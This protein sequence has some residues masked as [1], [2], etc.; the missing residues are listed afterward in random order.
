MHG[1]G[2]TGKEDFFERK[3][4]EKTFLCL[5]FLLGSFPLFRRLS[6][7]SEKVKTF[8][9]CDIMRE[10]WIEEALKS[11]SQKRMV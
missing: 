4:Y 3:R 1:E 2:I 11:R 8:S 7:F 10:I 9:G 6:S 5:P